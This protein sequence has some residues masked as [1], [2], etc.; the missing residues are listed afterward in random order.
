MRK[1]AVVNPRDSKHAHQVERYTD[2]KCG[3]AK[4]NKK[5]EQ[6]TKVNTPE[7]RLFDDIEWMKGVAN[8]VCS[9]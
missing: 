9:H 4:P 2:P 3:P 8:C 6:T 5:H 7:S 1:I